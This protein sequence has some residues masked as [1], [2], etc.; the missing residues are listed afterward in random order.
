MKLDSYLAA[1]PELNSKWF[2]T[3]EWN[4]KLLHETVWSTLY[5]TDTANDFMN[6]AH[7]FQ[8]VRSIFNK[9]SLALILDILLLPSVVCRGL[10]MWGNFC[11]PAVSHPRHQGKCFNTALASSPNAAHSKVQGHSLNLILSELAHPH[12]YQWG[13]LYHGA[14]VRCSRWRAEPAFLLAWTLS[15]FFHLPQAGSKE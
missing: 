12:P 9:W 8:E 4:L 15:Q 5:V 11:L 6:K 7:A 14:Q 1:Y 13:Y 2:R 10:K 3:A